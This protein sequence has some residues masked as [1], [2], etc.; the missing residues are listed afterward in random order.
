MGIY[1][2]SA[3]NLP[4]LLLV[5]G[6]ASTTSATPALMHYNLPTPITLSPN[7]VYWLGFNVNNLLR[8][9]YANNLGNM[10]VYNQFLGFKVSTS[11]ATAYQIHCIRSGSNIN[12]RLV[13][14][15]SQ[16]ATTY[17]FTGTTLGN[18]L[19]L[20]PPLL[21]VLKVTY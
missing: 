7:T 19:A 21:P 10:N 4:N 6:S 1:S 2:N 20:V 18:N 12:A 14:T 5:S 8:V 9:Y 3:T 13:P 11:A 15:A 17:T 16:V